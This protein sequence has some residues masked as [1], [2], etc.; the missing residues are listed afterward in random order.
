MLANV[1]PESFGEGHVAIRMRD[2]IVFFATKQ[3]DFSVHENWIYNLWT[4]QW[5]KCPTNVLTRG[6]EFMCIVPIGAV[7]YSYGGGSTFS[8]VY[9]VTQ[10]MDGAFDWTMIYMKK[11]QKP[12]PRFGHCGWEYGDKMWI[13]GGWGLSPVGYLNDY[14][15]F[16]GEFAASGS[17]GRFGVNNQLLS[18]DPSKRS[19]MNMECSG[20]IPSPRKY[21]SLAKIN[22]KV[23][24]FGGMTSLGPDD[25]LYEL[26]MYRLVWTHIHTGTP[27][28]RI[29]T[30]TFQDPMIG[31][32]SLLA[33]VTANQLVLHGNSV[34]GK[35]TWVFDVESKQWRQYPTGVKC[36]C[37]S[38]CC[39][40]ACGLNG[41]VIISEFHQD[42]GCNK[43]IFSVMLEPK[44]LQQL[45]MVIIHQNKTDLPW[46]SLPQSLLCKLEIEVVLMQS[47]EGI[48]CEIIHG[49]DSGILNSF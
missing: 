19:W 23:W 9:K 37:W 30:E 41:D 33:P 35:S 48:M 36:D 1:E 39:T 25:E 6:P 14:G 8:D 28:P 10:D 16:H 21:A 20:E 3:D 5:K 47:S 13:F 31:S 11:K 22:Y 29:F 24:L 40:G 17:F 49:E 34:E 42:T 12:S 18:Y 43:P 38:Y 26:N 7:M 46:Q 2:C 15:D 4:E 45:A 32:I 44:S 27:K